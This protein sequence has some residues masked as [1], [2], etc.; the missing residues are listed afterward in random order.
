MPTQQIA[1]T[2]MSCRFPGAENY[3]EY[4]NNLII[5]KN[6]VGET[7]LSRWDWRDHVDLSD[8]APTEYSRWAGFTKNPEQFD[9]AFFGVSPREAECMD[10]QQR[11][12]LEQAWHCIQDAGVDPR[13]LAGQNVG[14]Y[15]AAG[16]FDYKELQERHSATP[17]GHE[18]TGVHNSVI[19]NR[20]S[21]FFNLNGPS[22]VLDTACSS[23]LVAMQQAISAIQLGHCESALVGG[24][25]LLLTPTTFIRF[26]KMGMLS[27]TGQCSAFDANANGYVRG[28]GLGMLLLKPLD[29]AL[30]DGDRIWGVVKSVAINHGGKARSL[31]SPSALAQAKLIVD[32]VQQADIPVHSINFIETHGTGTPLGDP[33]EIHG[34]TRAFNQLQ[35]NSTTEQTAQYC[36]LGAV[37][38]SIGH[39]ECAAGMAGLIKVL[40]ALKHK[41]L[42]GHANFETINPRIKLA[43]SPFHI[44]EN[45]REWTPVMDHDGNP[46]P[47][48]AGI[49]S[50]GF[51]GVNGHIIMEEAPQGESSHSTPPTEPN[52]FTLL[53]ISAANQKSLQH[54][55]SAYA[56]SVNNTPDRYRELCAAANQAQPGLSYRKAVY[57]SSANDMALQ[58]AAF[59]EQASDAPVRDRKI[60]FVY[61]GQ[62]SQYAGM[63]SAL[64]VQNSVF[65]QALD[66]CD[67]LLQPLL[68]RSILEL[69]FDAN[70]SEIHLTQYTQPA[71]FALEYALTKMWQSLGIS[72][73]LIV[74]HSIG[75]LAGACISGVFSLEDALRI[76]VKR[77]QLMGSVNARGKMAAVF[78]TENEAKTLLQDL[79]LAVD[80]AAINAP[81]T[82]VI[83]GTAESVDAAID[84]FTQ[85]NIDSRYL[86]VSQAFHSVLMEPILNEFRQALSDIAFSAPKLKL[87]SNLTGQ[88]ESEA[89][90]SPDYWVNHV[91]NA[92]QYQAG[93]ETLIQQGV[94]HIVEIGPSSM[95]NS[96]AKRTLQ[97]H[98]HEATLIC[99]MKPD[100]PALTSLLK[101]MGQLFEAGCDPD[102]VAVTAR[103]NLK[104]VELP[105]YPFDRQAYW[106]AASKVPINRA[107]KPGSLA[108]PGEK[109]SLAMPDIAC[110]E[111][112]PTQDFG[113]YLLDHKVKGFSLMPAAG[114]VGCASAALA[115][116]GV[117]LNGLTI[118][119][120]KFLQPLH[121]DNSDHPLQTVLT[122]NPAGKDHWTINIAG[123]SAEADEWNIYATA[124]F[125]PVNTP[126]AEQRM[127]ARL[128]DQFK[129]TA[130]VPQPDF[131]QQCSNKG[132]EYGAAFQAVVQANKLDN[133]VYGHLCLPPMCD[134]LVPECFAIHPSLLDGALQLVTLLASAT[135]NQ[136]P[137][138]VGIERFTLQR[139]G[140]DNLYA[141]AELIDAE[142][143]VADITLYNR[144]GVLVGHIE[145]LEFRWVH[146]AQIAPV[147][148]TPSTHFYFVPEWQ[149]LPLGDVAPAVC[150]PLVIY[151]NE[152]LPL[153]NE[154]LNL[155]P[156]ASLCCM[157]DYQ[158]LKRCLSDSPPIDR[159]YLIWPSEQADAFLMRD[160]SEP[161]T[162]LLDV[163]QR[164][165][166]NGYDHHPIHWLIVSAANFS[167]VNETAESSQGLAL[168]GFVRS[169]CKEQSQWRASHI[170][171]EA[172]NTDT[173]RLL[174]HIEMVAA[175]EDDSVKECVVRGSRYWRR[176]LV[177]TPPPA[178]SSPAA[179]RKG[180]VYLITGGA[181]GIGA[182]LAMKLASEHSAKL[183]LLGRSPRDTQRIEFEQRLKTLGGEATYIS[184]DVADYTLLRTAVLQA[185]QLFGPIQGVIHSAGVVNDGV[186]QNMTPL[187]L[188][189]VCAPKIQGTLNLYRAVSDQPLDFML[190]FSSVMAWLSYAGQANY[191]AANAFI[192]GFARVV[193]PRSTFPVK[194]INWGHWGET[195]MAS[196]DYYRERI[197]RMGIQ[198]ISTEEGLAAIEAVV[199]NDW[200]QLVVMKAHENVLTEM[201]VTNRKPSIAPA[202][203][204]DTFSLPS[205]D[206][207]YD[208]QSPE[209]TDLLVA[210]LG[211]LI[212]KAM[213]MDTQ[214]LLSDKTAFL[215]L[216]FT[217]LGIDS[218]TTVDLRK[219]IRDWL[220]VDVPAEVLIGG[221]V[222]GEVIDLL[223]Q[224][225]LLQ[226]LSHVSTANESSDESSN[227]DEE[228]F[229]L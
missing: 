124:D 39:L 14:V 214:Q 59:Q 1:I 200:Q 30:A 3:R 220:D 115:R 147:N 179:F 69:M 95:L 28:E 201:G 45:T 4:W 183:I 102:F 66:D 212:A 202:V 180:G 94:T 164:L 149:S 61:S 163:A 191:V 90:C 213:R 184:V 91:R 169:L 181:Q 53:T 21:Y 13:T 2:G 25:G 157:G 38:A 15:I 96:L 107:R 150:N 136:I 216:R 210:S 101:A 44:V 71:L 135:D 19:A 224:Q 112:N 113:S 189:Q 190:L 105:L 177:Q 36:G 74:G 108:M 67:N 42:P 51:G 137:L 125:I 156:S 219:R 5:G 126:A 43:D 63:G 159:I 138:P 222:I 178:L 196:S 187:M 81:T 97:Y 117:A 41:T 26:G 55:A 199:V 146:A 188:Q 173:A 162:F 167:V 225:I 20:I 64:Y 119:G 89:F 171:I 160:H 78:T 226:R 40:L 193:S 155:H 9:A 142:N 130:T 99:S 143:N 7:P 166:A 57:A 153:V 87:I 49:S 54:L 123:R 37:K 100:E 88:L 72:P 84:T 50:F 120:L 48:R 16:G 172:E 207:L 114:F 31:T 134:A 110:F 170:D 60:A 215:K 204:T 85:K 211:A 58:L 82:L 22:M 62:G 205:I 122:R 217:S 198:E 182:S 47:L 56:T 12:I 121:L 185:V 104:S 208:L 33:I 186:V 29:Q 229:V 75:E 195:G 23:S 52:A 154:L 141:V 32:A 165:L 228:V 176:A 221:A 116:M 194:V 152:S 227:E 145:R 17:E 73:D 206:Q 10:P 70:S 80:V 86:E 46:F 93:I 129:A 218:L 133:K 175:A 103:A 197:A 148:T 92:V 11:L 83:S 174:K 98:E 77:G 161:L 27:P 34:L 76:V 223:K 158:G 109:L 144:E 118:T 192:D 111:A 209:T 24:V 131:Y 35:K 168:A 18:A 203:E 106:I 68:N 140:D 8:G 151:A 6:L 127:D 128:F 139:S 65:K 132:L 79:S